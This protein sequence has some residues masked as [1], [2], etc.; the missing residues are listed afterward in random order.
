M[1]V[2]M[3]GNRCGDLTARLLAR[4]RSAFAL[5]A[6]ARARDRGRVGR[7]WHVLPAELVQAVEQIA[8]VLDEEGDPEQVQLAVQ[9]AFAPAPVFAPPPWTQRLFD[10]PAVLERVGAGFGDDE[11]WPALG[12]DARVSMVQRALAAVAIALCRSPDS[13]AAAA[14]RFEPHLAEQLVRAGRLAHVTAPAGMPS[15]L[16]GRIKRI[17]NEERRG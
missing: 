10:D 4:G 15:R 14:A 9:A 6:V 1:A 13:V 7:S 3:E 17:L 12:A 5:A 2:D 11:L 8:G 16:R